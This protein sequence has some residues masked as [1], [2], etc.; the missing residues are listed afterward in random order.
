[1]AFALPAV[2]AWA[3]LSWVWR[4]EDATGSAGRTESTSITVSRAP[5]ARSSRVGCGS[6]P[7]EEN[8]RELPDRPDLDQ[9]RRQARALQRDAL[10]GDPDALRRIRSVSNRITLTTAQLAIARKYGFSSWARLKAKVERR[11][12][13]PDPAAADFAIRPVA[14]VDELALVFDIV[15]ALMASGITH[16]M[17]VAEDRGRVVGGALMFNTTLRAIALE[18]A[19]RGK[20]LGRCLVEAIE[21]EAARLGRSGISLGVGP[22][23]SSAREFF[24]HMGY[25]GRSRMGKQLPLSPDIRYGSDAERGRRL[26]EVRARRVHRLTHDSH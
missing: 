14:S 3:L 20:G 18:P 6:R 12:L 26:E 19:A 22:D 7:L 24:A 9:L 4:R 11:R 21:K 1:V 13:Q 10:A 23:P 16:L 25:S 5:I 15:F 17:L 2:M 8:M